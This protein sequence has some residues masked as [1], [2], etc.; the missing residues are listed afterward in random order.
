MLLTFMTLIFHARMDHFEVNYKF[1]FLFASSSP[2]NSTSYYKTDFET[3][4]SYYKTYGNM[5][6][7]II[8]S[9]LIPC[10]QANQIDKKKRA[11]FLKI[12]E[13]FVRKRNNNKNLKE[14]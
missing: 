5:V 13:Y 14:S 10:L 1:V 4:L 6:Q 11:F 2:N 8:I 12:R 3:E 9:F 7:I